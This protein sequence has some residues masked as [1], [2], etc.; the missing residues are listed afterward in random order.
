MTVNCPP[1]SPKWRWRRKYLFFSFHPPVTNTRL[2]GVTLKPHLDDHQVDLWLIL[3]SQNI[4]P[5]VW[6][7][8]HYRSWLITIWSLPVFDLSVSV[9]CSP[10]CLEAWLPPLPRPAARVAK[11]KAPRR[12]PQW[13]ADGWSSDGSRLQSAVQER[14]LLIRHHP[15]S[16]P[17]AGER[18]GGGQT[19]Q[20]LTPGVW[21]LS[22]AFTW[23]IHGSH[24]CTH[25]ERRGPAHTNTHSDRQMCSGSCFL[26][27]SLVVLFFSAMRS[28]R[29]VFLV[30]PASH[31]RGRQ[32]PSAFQ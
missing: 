26:C 22:N 14:K 11:T 16:G 12:P 28:L 17:G 1:Q 13:K 7:N 15:S 31:R 29:K 2:T 24:S 9:L 4:K 3:S 21:P 19:E 20:R 30:D 18:R 6:I 23:H 8:L 27:L 32:I 10:P 25:V 5:C